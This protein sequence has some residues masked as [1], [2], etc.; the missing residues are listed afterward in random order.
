M[1]QFNDRVRETTTVTGTGTMTLLGA[2]AGFQSF[3]T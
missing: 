2:V 3:S 1:P